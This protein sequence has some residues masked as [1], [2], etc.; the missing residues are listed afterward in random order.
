MPVSEMSKIEK[1]ELELQ[2]VENSESEV[3]NI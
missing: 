3:P 1:A 2:K